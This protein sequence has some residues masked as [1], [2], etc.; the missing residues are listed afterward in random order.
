MPIIDRHASISDATD[1]PAKSVVAVSPSDAN[2]LAFVCKALLC[3]VAGNVSIIA[4][5]DTAPVTIPL[6]VGQLL[7]VRVK[8][9]RATGTTATVLALY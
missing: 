4:Q 1:Y 2:D 8:R 6:T 9:V 3:T 7:P 5:E